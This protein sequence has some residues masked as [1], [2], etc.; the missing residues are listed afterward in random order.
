M[1]VSWLPE[2]PFQTEQSG[3]G[4]SG[5]RGA[6]RRSQ[7]DSGPAK[8]RRIT[9]AG[10]RA[11]SM[12]IPQLSLEQIALFEAWFEGALASGALA[13]EAVHPHRGG[14]S[15]FCFT[16]DPAYGVTGLADGSHKLAFKLDELPR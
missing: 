4:W 11:L 12:S 1:T 3:A 6:V 13:F 8:R 9:T 7:M 10:P 16:D 14:L 15:L 2:I 5:P